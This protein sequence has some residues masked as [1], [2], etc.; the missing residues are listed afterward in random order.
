MCGLRI[1]SIG[2][3]L[4]SFASIH[5]QGLW[6]QGELLLVQDDRKITFFLRYGEV[7]AAM[8]VKILLSL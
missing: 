1:V 4:R 6:H 3:Y 7:E 8:D 5:S 2:H